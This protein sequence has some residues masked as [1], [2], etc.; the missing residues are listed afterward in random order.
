MENALVPND[1]ILINI[2]MSAMKR[3]SNM[4]YTPSSNNSI[5]LIAL[6]EKVHISAKYFTINMT[7]NLITH[8]ILGL[9]KVNL[10]PIR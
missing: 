6:P 3:W 10:S 9:F 5:D 8:L 1:T 2:N 7:F 4:G